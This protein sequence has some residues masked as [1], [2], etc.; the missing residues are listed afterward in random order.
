ML[1]E[2]AE[3]VIQGKTVE[4]NIFQPA[5]WAERLCDSLANK[6]VDGRK[7]HSSFVRPVVTEGIKAVVVRVALQKA[8]PEAFDMIKRYIAENH[9]MVRSGRGS[10]DAESGEPPPSVGRERRDPSRNTW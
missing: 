1:S 2:T 9:L 7:M 8:D 5:D 3:F 10:R 4:G 6:G